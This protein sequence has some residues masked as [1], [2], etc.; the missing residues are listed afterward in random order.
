MANTETASAVR[1]HDDEAASE[2]LWYQ[3]HLNNIE[4]FARNGGKFVSLQDLAQAGLMELLS[5]A[6]HH[7]N[8]MLSSQIEAA[9]SAG[10]PTQIRGLAW[11]AFLD[12]RVRQNKG[13]YGTLVQRALGELRH[14]H[15]L[16]ASDIKQHMAASAVAAATNGSALRSSLDIAMPAAQWAPGVSGENNVA[17]VEED[18]IWLAS[19]REWL[20]QIE[21]DLKRT[22]AGHA[23]MS[24][25]GRLALRRILAAYALHNPGVGYCQGT[26]YIAAV[27]M[28]FLSEE[29]TFYCL[30]AVVEEVMTGYYA[31]DMQAAQV[32]QAVFKQL[33]STELPA[34]AQHLEA[35][36]ADI[37]CVFAQWFLCAFINFLPLPAVLR[38]WDLLFWRRSVTVLFQVSLALVDIYAPALLMTQDV[39]D[40]FQVVQQ[41]APLTHDATHLL[42]VAT[43]RFAHINGALLEHLREG[44]SK[45]VPG[46]CIG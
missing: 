39:L 4:L 19:G 13:Y 16:D 33:V 18:A 44:C 37:S 34:V 7:G 5:E 36:G 20:Q 12:L 15:S 24:E 14:Q 43:T 17:E 40:A 27:L 29:D 25:G 21:K 32:D 46:H 1:Q 31:L 38:V 26:N 45:Q 3:L 11:K 28:M 42:H 8:K 30:A 10:L 35:R 22:F 6:R 41:M 23:V 9:V 2:E